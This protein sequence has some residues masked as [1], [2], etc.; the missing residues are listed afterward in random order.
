MPTTNVPPITFGANGFQ[1]PTEQAILVGVQADINA[2][3]G[4]NLN[5]GLS[6]PQGQLATSTAAI[7]GNVND[8]F[9]YFCNQVDPAYAT[10]RMQDAIARIYFLERNP[11]LPTVLQ[12]NCV[13]A[14]GVP[15]PIGSTIVDEANNIYTCTNAG[16]IGANGNVQLAFAN[17]VVGPIAVPGSTEVSIYQ[18]IPGWDSVTVVSGTVGQN[19]ETRQAFEAR[20]AASVAANS[21]GSLPSVQGAVLSVPGVLDAY[22]TENVSSSAQTIGGVLLASK[23]LYVAVTGGGAA[24]IAQA[25]WS[26]KAPGCGYNGNTTVAVQDTNSGYNEPYPSY[27]V[28]FEVP[29]GLAIL[30]AVQIA[31]NA[32]VPTNAIQQIQSAILNAFNGG[33]GGPR[34]R[35]GSTLYASRY[36]PPLIALG[37]WVQI[38]S[39]EIGS[40]NTPNAIFDGY[41][42]GNTLNV[43]S[44][45]SGS[46]AVG[47]TLADGSGFVSAGTLITALGTGVGGTGTYTLNASLAVGASFIGSGSGETLTASSVN[48][49]ITPGLILTGGTG[50]IAGTII[51]QQL[52]GTLGGAGTYQTSAIINIAP[53]TNCTV[54]EVMTSALPN[55]SSVQV[56]INQ[57]PTIATAN[58]AVTT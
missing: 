16:A 46:L 5:P 48:G 18:A 1:A 20:R 45:S 29:S 12:I 55:Q 28:S 4:G 34:A 27:N 24:A 47:Q 11:A 21:A 41:I 2:A 57:E 58:I 50:V 23:S 32:Q 25:I 10:G 39:L 3:F 49:T 26:K 19:T 33:D 17:N 54:G 22:T 43:T 38:T 37:P 36:I 30:F 44:I 13:G 8:T 52:S 14:V 6:T 51:V 35:I 9:L 31:N 56:N 40:I 15:I 7:I 42:L 53:S